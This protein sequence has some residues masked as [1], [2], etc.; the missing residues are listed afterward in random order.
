MLIIKIKKTL[1]RIILDQL[2]HQK[3]D[4]KLKTKIIK[5]GHQMYLLKHWIQI[6][7][8]NNSKL[9]LNLS[10]K[11]LEYSVTT[12]RSQNNSRKLIHQH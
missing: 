12:S 6:L 3:R 11:D 1:I 2:T 5:D 8:T 4:L 7:Q 10:L 9:I